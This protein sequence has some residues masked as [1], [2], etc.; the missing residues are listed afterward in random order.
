M[1][2]EDSIYSGSEHNQFDSLRLVKREAGFPNPRQVLFG[3]NQLWRV[4]E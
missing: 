2:G 1:W 3:S 4:N